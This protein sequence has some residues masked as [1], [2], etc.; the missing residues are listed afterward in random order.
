MKGKLH[1]NVSHMAQNG[2]ALLKNQGGRIYEKNQLTTVSGLSIINSL[3]PCTA[4]FL[5]D[6][7]L[8]WQ[9]DNLLLAPMT[10]PLISA[11]VS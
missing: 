6:R 3:L 2:S 9:I 10:I 4:F 11:L 1:D 5:F 7:A 8:I